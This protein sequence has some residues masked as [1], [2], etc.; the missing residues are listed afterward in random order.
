MNREIPPELENRIVRYASLRECKGA[1][2]DTYFEGSEDKVNFQVIGGGVVENPS[3][4]VHIS[5]PHGFNIGGTRKSPG[6]TNNQHS[7]E[8]TEVFLV[9][10]GQ[11]R[12]KIGPTGEDGQLDV[13]EGDVIAFPTRVFRGFTAIGEQT[14]HLVSVLGI[15]AGRVTWAP[16]VFEKARELG[17]VTSP[18]WKCR[19][20]AQGR[21]RAR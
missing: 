16:Y 13:G 1:F 21:I 9:H 3:K 10:R 17:P 11:Y 19:R 14:A 15:P 4:Y 8:N 12:M 2:I 6:V 20:Y 18:K 7:H 5:I